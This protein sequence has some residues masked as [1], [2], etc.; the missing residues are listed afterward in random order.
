M[1]SIR[2][3]D[4]ILLDAIHNGTTTEIFKAS[5]AD[6]E[7][8][9]P[10]IA[11]KRLV[12]DFVDDREARARLKEEARVAVQL[13]HTNLIQVLDSGDIEGE[14][15]I[16]TEYVHGKDLRDIFLRQQ[17]LSRRL[18]LALPCFIA[19]QACEG[20]HYL[21][22]KKNPA[23]VP[24]ELFH[25]AVSPQNIVISYDGHVKL[26]DFSRSTYAVK[27]A[28]RQI[29][30]ERWLPGYLSPEQAQP[31]DLDFRTDIF[32]VG[33]CLYE[34]LTGERLF[35]DA[36]DF[37]ALQQ[38]RNLDV[39]S[40]RGLN[41]QIP[42]ELEHIIL[43]ALARDRVDRYQTAM[44]LHDHL[45]SFMYDNRQLCGKKELGDHVRA[46][47][48]DES[49]ERDA[50]DNTT[51]S[52]IDDQD[53]REKTGLIAFEDLQPVAVTKLTT[54]ASLQRPEPSQ[55]APAEPRPVSSP[56]MGTTGSVRSRPPAPSRPP[57]A[58]SSP[59]SPPR[60][61]ATLLGLPN[62]PQ[63]IFQP[64]GSSSSG[65]FESA[66]T[67]TFNPGASLNTPAMLPVPQPNSED[68]PT[69]QSLE[70]ERPVSITRA[71]VPALVPDLDA[72]I[73]SRPPDLDD[74]DE[75]AKTG[76]YAMSY[77]LKETLMA[78]LAKPTPT[79]D[80]DTTP[81]SANVLPLQKGAVQSAG[82]D[83]TPIGAEFQKP[84]L[85]STGSWLAGASSQPN[86]II[87][88]G[89]VVITGLILVAGFL[90]LKKPDTGVVNLTTSPTDTSVKINGQLF[91]ATASPFVISGLASDTSH[92]IEVS[93][94]G[95]GNWST[96]VTLKA[97]QELSLPPVTLDPINNDTGFTIDSK[98]RGAKVFI[99]NK[100]IA[101]TTP[102]RIIGLDPGIYDIRIENGS[103]FAPWKSQVKVTE[104]Q[105]IELPTAELSPQTIPTIPTVSA[106]E[107]S[108]AERAEK[109]D[110]TRQVAS[111]ITAQTKAKTASSDWLRGTTKA[112]SASS[113]SRSS[114]RTPR[115][116]SEPR[117]TS[118]P[119]A[120]ASPAKSSKQG[121]LRINS[122]P[123]AQ[124]FVDNRL[125]GNTPQMG[126]TLP[127]G[128][129]NITLVNPTFG[130]KK[131]VA[132]DVKANET[133]TKIISLTP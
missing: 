125:V 104:N 59:P 7:D 48:D 42:E 83:L 73:A 12:A 40:P 35:T 3:G 85:S 91:P 93:K 38:V 117:Q 5:R 95:Y 49:E 94:P 79:V 102:A 69:N 124:V 8:G 70:M 74:E 115:A 90:L 25:G 41:R 118:A 22:E 132:V 109:K 63:A 96:S 56:A 92:L 24:L 120:A 58:Q 50:E 116:T 32:N 119:A 76:L 75:E 101:K 84:E 128:K 98:P 130:M 28:A 53:R 34:L 99:D 113:S 55:P 68:T 65:G 129:H 39:P 133:V 78:A 13:T 71:A 31:G 112:P 2:F 43:K 131:T 86:F 105:V 47:F 23:G 103:S 52:D 6:G 37:S 21:H 9:K 14:F 1:H 67:T 33:I 107:K 26:I 11:I 97:G 4:Y 72:T 57:R 29:E 82:N 87:R 10:N 121:T 62:V 89:A 30:D 45:Q 51:I 60:Y 18:P 27:A 17:S 80:Q 81:I 77:E 66:A 19:M 54:L 61:Q 46:L 64:S 114:T 88:A 127:A 111:A 106:P 100:D 16:A 44:E 123:W 108:V 36:T 122:R 110:D 20:L 15:F 126:L